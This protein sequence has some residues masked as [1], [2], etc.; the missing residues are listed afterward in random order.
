MGAM[1][2]DEIIKMNAKYKNKNKVVS[3][4][5]PEEQLLLNTLAG[6]DLLK[7]SGSGHGA[8]YIYSLTPMSYKLLEL[9]S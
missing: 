7:V 9:C 2:A 8:D 4:E 1:S 5:E 6:F 3:A